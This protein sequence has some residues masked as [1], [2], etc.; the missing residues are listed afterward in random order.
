MTE[1]LELFKFTRLY[2]GASNW[3]YLKK[4]SQ[5]ELAL[6]K[7]KPIDVNKSYLVYGNQ[8]LLNK[9]KAFYLTRCLK[10]RPIYEQY[11]MYDYAN[12]LCSTTRDEYGINLDLDLLF[13]YR[14]NHPLTIGRSEGWLIETVLNK[15]ASRNRE[16]LVTVILSEVKMEDL[17]KCG[18]FEVINLSGVQVAQNKEEILKEMKE[19]RTKGTSK[20]DD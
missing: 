6:F 9:F 13:L 12:E 16:G 18:E 3:E 10:K 7:D 1:N 14:H 17:N 15:V 4:T 11:Q 8:N 19:Q 20:Y 5:E 2:L